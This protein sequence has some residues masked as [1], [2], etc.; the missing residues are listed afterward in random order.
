MVAKEAERDVEEVHLSTRL[1]EDLHLD[2][3]DF[4]VVYE[5]ADRFGV[6]MRDYRWYHHSGMEGCNPLWFILPPWWMR[7]KQ[8]P[9]RVADLVTAAESGRWPIVYHGE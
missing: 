3:D 7:A 9:V 8:I 2:G 6:D 1:V 4:D 5:V